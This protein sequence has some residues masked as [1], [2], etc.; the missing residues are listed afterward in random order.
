MEGH[1]AREI[2]VRA[3]RTI[4]ILDDDDAVREALGDG[5]STLGFAVQA[6]AAPAELFA[7]PFATIDCLLLDYDLPHC[8]GLAV[9][10]RLAE[11]G[12]IAPI[13]FI[14]ATASERVVVAA[15][16]AGAEAF[17]RKPVRLAELEKL[18]GAVMV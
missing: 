8:N 16:A 7:A 5:V 11:C 13:V 3:E 9:Q 4:A 10:A 15:L 18:L 1:W 2:A 14:S 6:F 17:L 12:F